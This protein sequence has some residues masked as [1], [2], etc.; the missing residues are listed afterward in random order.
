MDHI[1][2]I[3]IVSYNLLLTFPPFS[4]RSSLVRVRLNT[5]VYISRMMQESI[6]Q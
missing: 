1:A 3:R 6:D 5:R 4:I 2:P